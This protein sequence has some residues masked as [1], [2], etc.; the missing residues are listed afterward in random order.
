MFSITNSK[1]EINFYIKL[2]IG[3]LYY[4]A[5]RWSN[6]AL[7]PQEIIDIAKN[8]DL[9]S[10]LRHKGYNLIADSKS[11][12]GKDRLTSMTALL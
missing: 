9:L 6:L 4:S 1:I 10:Y 8:T 12:R 2:A 3:Q 5:G 11:P 7:I